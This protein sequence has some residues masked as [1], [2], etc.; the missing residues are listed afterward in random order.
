MTHQYARRTFDEAQELARLAFKSS[1]AD[2]LTPEEIEEFATNGMLTGGTV[3]PGWEPIV[4]FTPDDHWYYELEIYKPS[5]EKP[6]ISKSFARML[7][8]RDRTLEAVSFIWRP[9]TSA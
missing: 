8:P 5:A 4:G 3:G 2:N 1:V 7:V 6:Y 9:S